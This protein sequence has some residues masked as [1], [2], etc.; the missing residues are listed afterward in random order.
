MV[1]A[2]A[3][4]GWGAGSA[5]APVGTGRELLP[6]QRAANNL[7]LSFGCVAAVSSLSHCRLSFVAV[8]VVI[9]CMCVYRHKPASR[10]GGLGGKHRRAELRHVPGKVPLKR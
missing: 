1:A 8:S 7:K 2:C 3:L 9:V 5:G 10:M 6:L 4:G